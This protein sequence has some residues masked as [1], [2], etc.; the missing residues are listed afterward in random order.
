VAQTTSLLS[1][2]D[3]GRLV[4]HA[5]PQGDVVPDYSG[6]GYR[7]SEVAIP[8]VP[9]VL[10]VEPVAGDNRAHVQRAIDEVAARAPNAHGFRGAI[11]FRAG[12]YEIASTVYVRADGVVLRG[13]GAGED[14]TR[15]V[16][17]SN[18]QSDCVR[19]E[20]AGGITLESASRR[21][22]LGDY[23]PFGATRVDVGGGH[24]FEVG[25][26]VVIHHQ[27]TQA[28]VDLLDM[29]RYG[30]TPAGS[31]YRA[32][33][34]IVAIEGSVLELDAPITDPI[35]SRYAQTDVVRIASSARL[36]HVGIEH[37]R[38]VST[39]ASELDVNHGWKAVAFRRVENAWARH[40]QA[41]HFGYSVVSIE[42]EQTIFVTVEHCLMADPKSGTGG[43]NR[44][45]FDNNGQRILVQHC[46]SIG[47]G[48]HCFVSGSWTPGPSVFHDCEA[49]D[50]ISDSGPHHRWTTGHLYDNVVT[51]HELRVRNRRA[52]GS[53]H[54]WT[55]AQIM[56]WN[57][58]IDHCVVQDPPGPFTN[59]AIGT[60]GR[61]SAGNDGESIGWVEST[62]APITAV[63]SLFQAQL[64][65]R[66]DRLSPPVAIATN[67]GSS[68]ANISTRG[69][70]GE[71]AAV[72]IAGFVVKGSEDQTVL[73]RAVGPSLEDL[74]VQDVLL[75]PVLTLYKEG[76]VEP[77]AGS[78]DWRGAQT[79]EIAEQVGAYAL[80]PGSRDAALVVTLAPGVYTARV[81]GKEGATGIALVEVYEVD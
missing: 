37:I 2:A 5:T 72:L 42:D 43:G 57:S 22:I 52:S 40:L 3:D 45:A 65:E 64:R 34:K 60:V 14:G 7:N 78:D 55:G 29:A 74:G 23:V 41:F 49:V 10:V 32:E 6:V 51:D 21:R 38:F 18:V 75:D 50:A 67:S 11:L 28:W 73:V 81:T 79:A 80:F 54:G 53:G 76:V 30:W 26:E 70:V 39:Y 25:D 24:P 77:I 17:T 36:K 16:Y 35:D 68:L 1:V 4:Y 8:D 20:G 47:G 9:V 69:F 48:R 63:P 44:Y 66:L 61:V 15:F 13:E 12:T 62:G 33:R 27:P 59:W 56:I 46:R 71:G 31:A 58:V 19:F